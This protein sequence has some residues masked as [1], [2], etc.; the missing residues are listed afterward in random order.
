MHDGAHAAALPRRGTQ[1]PMAGD[2]AGPLVPRSGGRRHMRPRTS[3]AAR[4]RACASRVLGTPRAA[5][6][7]E[8]AHE[9]FGAIFKM[10]KIR[11][12]GL[13]PARP[14]TARMRMAIVV[15]LLML[16]PSWGG[17]MQQA[18]RGDFQMVGLGYTAAGAEAC[19]APRTGSAHASRA[20]CVHGR[21]R[22]S[23]R[24]KEGRACTQR[25]RARWL[26]PCLR[27]VPPSVACALSTWA[28]RIFAYHNALR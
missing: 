14:R 4:P 17:V 27:P 13:V 2:T 8:G 7:Q 5:A 23:P 6:V 25:P 10:E 9:L 22:I 15:L 16:P 1:A 20:R 28:A 3:T 19:R 11:R 18:R 26:S 12:G 24:G 21:L